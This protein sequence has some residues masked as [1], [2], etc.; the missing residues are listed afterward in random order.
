MPY[1]SDDNRKVNV[2][3]PESDPTWTPEVL[4][5]L[6]RYNS[7]RWIPVDENGVH[8]HE[9]GDW[10]ITQAQLLKEGG[11]KRRDCT[12]CGKR[13][14]AS[15]TEKD[16][17]A[18]KCGDEAVWR[19]YKSGI[20]RIDGKGDLWGNFYSP[21]AIGWLSEGETREDTYSKTYIDSKNIKKVVVGRQIG[22]I[23]GSMFSNCVNLKQIRFLCKAPKLS[24]SPAE[25]PQFKTVRDLYKGYPPFPHGKGIGGP[26]PG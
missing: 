17:I 5:A 15:I 3:Y 18:G 12:I 7:C 9:W 4:K 14:T 20:L 6:G 1:I 25:E 21:S 19:F 24:V 8:H 16:F 11:T 22:R 26:F 2:Y 23:G 13:E 10:V